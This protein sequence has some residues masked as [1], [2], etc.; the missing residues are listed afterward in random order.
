VVTARRNAT[1]A[2][3]WAQLRGALAPIDAAFARFAAL[4]RPSVESPRSPTGSA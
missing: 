3:S 1:I 4:V 2:L